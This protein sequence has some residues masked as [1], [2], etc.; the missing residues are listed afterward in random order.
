MIIIFL[1]S[2]LAS[3]TPKLFIQNFKRARH[4]VQPPPI[5]GTG[6]IVL[7]ECVW[8]TIGTQNG[9][10]ENYFIIIYFPSSSRPGH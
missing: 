5:M 9:G 8:Q 6:I 2:P 7:E 4:N 1:I 10:N 3:P